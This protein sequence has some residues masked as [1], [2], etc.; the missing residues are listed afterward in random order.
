LPVNRLWIFTEEAQESVL[1]RVLCLTVMSM[2][3]D[4]NPIDCLTTLVRE[5]SI[6]LVKKT[7]SFSIGQTD[8]D[9]IAWKKRVT[10]AYGARNAFQRPLEASVCGRVGGGVPGSRDPLSSSC[11]H[12]NHADVCVFAWMAGKCVS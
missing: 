8:D 10:P 11:G 7:W 12:E 4:R 2:L 3:V 6:S 9:Q 1:K 5:V